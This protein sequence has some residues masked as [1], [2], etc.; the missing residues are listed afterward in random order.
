MLY[1]RFPGKEIV[2]RKGCFKPN[3]TDDIQ[4]FILS[5]FNQEKKYV[6]TASSPENNKVKKPEANLGK[7]VTFSKMKTNFVFDDDRRRRR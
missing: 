1:Y 4:G 7:S 6:F 2:S 3:L 5:D